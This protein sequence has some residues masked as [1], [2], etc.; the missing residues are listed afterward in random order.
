MHKKFAAIF[1]FLFLASQPTLAKNFKADLRLFGGSATVDPEEANTEFQLNN[2]KKVKTLNQFGIEATYPL[3][4]F[5]D[6]GLRYTKGI[7]KVGEQTAVNFFDYYADIQQDNMM[8]VLRIPFIRTGIVRFDAFGGVGVSNTFVTLKTSTQD[9]KMTS[10]MSG[11]S[12]Y[13]GSVSIGYKR[14]FLNAEAGF[15][16]NVASSFER[17]GTVNSNIDKLDLSG[18]YFTVGLMFAGMTGTKSSGKK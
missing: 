13:G 2:I 11:T 5:V 7:A 10:N 1:V 17:T 9:G 15:Q 12:A 3:A 16:S 6:I 14:F 8:G 4:R 18:S